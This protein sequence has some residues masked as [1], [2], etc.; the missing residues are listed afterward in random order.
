MKFLKRICYGVYKMLNSI[1][2]WL[3]FY[4]I[5]LLWG[6]AIIKCFG[7]N[8]YLSRNIAFLN[9]R[10]ISIGNNCVLNSGIILDGRGAALRIGNNVD[11]AQDVNVWTQ[12]HDTMSCDHRLHSAAVIINANVWI[13]SRAII[14]P[15]VTIGEGAVIAAG[16]VVTKNVEPFSIVAGVPA[17]KIGM[18]NDNLNYILN[19]KPF[20]E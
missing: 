1:I 19:Y 2:M 13:A 3:P 12:E 18:R 5:R 4:Y 16:A 14:L 8:I 9:P 15:G 11:I 17:K 20:F 10:N 6:K 7:K